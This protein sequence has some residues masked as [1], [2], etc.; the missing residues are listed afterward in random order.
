[1]RFVAQGGRLPQAPG[2]QEDTPYATVQSGGEDGEGG[3]KGA[4]QDEG[5]GPQGSPKGLPPQ[6]GEM[7]RRRG[8]GGLAARHTELRLPEGL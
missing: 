4:L 5:R 8:W 6:E 1:M 7:L 3:K 2:G